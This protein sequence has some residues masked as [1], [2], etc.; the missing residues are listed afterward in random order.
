MQTPARQ[1]HGNAAACVP[2]PALLAPAPPAAPAG[3]L[4][5]LGAP[6]TCSMRFLRSAA[7]GCPSKFIN[8]TAG[9]CAG[10]R[11]SA[12]V[13]LNTGPPAR[14]A[15]ESKG[16]CI[17]GQAN[18]QIQAPIIGAL[19][20]PLFPVPVP[21]SCSCPVQSSLPPVGIMLPCH[22]TLP[23]HPGGRVRL[24]RGAAA[25]ACRPGR[26][27]A[28]PRPPHTCRHN[29]RAR[30]GNPAECL[31]KFIVGWFGCSAAMPLAAHTAS[32]PERA[33]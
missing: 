26:P 19:P 15:K 5:R 3:Y 7:S 11:A 8:R 12:A 6:P 1:A 17:L 27:A 31:Q 4:A 30:V 9:T 28:A 32:P 24:D 23:S 13:K 25:S 16:A 20:P 14:I 21:P 33:P 2:S 10:S 29:G 18:R 22:T